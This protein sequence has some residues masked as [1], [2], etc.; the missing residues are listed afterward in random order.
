M[1]LSASRDDRWIARAVFL[2]S[3]V[4]DSLKIRIEAMK[5]P[6]VLGQY[7]LWKVVKYVLDEYVSRKRVQFLAR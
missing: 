1:A 7:I 2:F 5:P 6:K 4:E 3:N